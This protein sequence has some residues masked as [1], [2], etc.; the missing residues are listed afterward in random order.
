MTAATV[1][2]IATGTAIG[3]Q[4]P[5]PSR[6]TGS[7]WRARLPHCEYTRRSFKKRA[8]K[9]AVTIGG[10]VVFERR[11]CAGSGRS[12]PAAAKASA[13]ETRRVGCSLSRLMVAG[14]E[15]MRMRRLEAAGGS[16]Y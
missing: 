14:V 7:A 2:T 5:V 1:T 3:H 6:V 11:R 12:S 15:A 9:D 8:A 13:T 16:P 10:L 4:S